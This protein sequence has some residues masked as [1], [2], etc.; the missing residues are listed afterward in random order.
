MDGVQSPLPP[1]R[2]QSAGHCRSRI[3]PGSIPL[4]AADAFFL[5]DRYGL[6][7][8]TIE[9]A[10]LFSIEGQDHL[11]GLGA[12]LVYAQLPSLIGAPYLASPDHEGAV[13]WRVWRQPGFTANLPLYIPPGNDTSPVAVLTEDEIAALG[14]AQLGLRAVGLQ[15]AASALG[16]MDEIAAQLLASGVKEV[17]ILF[18]VERV[19]ASTSV[20]AHDRV[21]LALACAFS[22]EKHG[23]PT[24]VVE[25]PEKYVTAGKDDDGQDCWRVEVAEAVGC[26]LSREEIDGAVQRG[27]SFWHHPA[28]PHAKVVAMW[29][30]EGEGVLEHIEDWKHLLARQPSGVVQDCFS[31]LAG[32]C[33]GACFDHH[34]GGYSRPL[35]DAITR[36]LHRVVKE[37]LPGARLS[38]VRHFI[39]GVQAQLDPLA[40]PGR[41]SLSDFGLEIRDGKVFRKPT[42]DGARRL[43]A[44]FVP[45]RIRAGHVQYLGCTP[46]PLHES[47]V[48]VGKMAEEITVRIHGSLYDGNAFRRASQGRLEVARPQD[49]KTLMSYLVE[50]EEIVMPDA[51][52]NQT[53]HVGIVAEQPGRFVVSDGID[54]PGG[55]EECPY[56]GVQFSSTG[57][58]AFFARAAKLSTD[59][60]VEIILVHALGAPLKA[61]TGTWP[62]NGVE[63]DTTS[64]KSTLIDRVLH[65]LE[66]VHF[67]PTHFR[68]SY[69]MKKALSNA[70]IPIALDEIGRISRDHRRVLVD[71]LN[72]S[73]GITPSTHGDGRRVYIV[74]VPAILFG[75]DLAMEDDTALATKMIKVSLDPAKKDPEALKAL[76]ESEAHFPTR[77]WLEFLADHMGRHDVHA[78]I[79]E[80][81]ESMRADVF[82]DR[83]RLPANADRFL[84]N[85]AA[86]SYAGNI[87]KAFGTPVS[88]AFRQNLLRAAKVHFDAITGEVGDGEDRTSI[89]KQIVHDL[90]A[91]AGTTK[92]KPPFPMIL[93]ARGLLFHVPTAVRYLQRSG[94]R[95]DITSPTAAT[96][97]LRELGSPGHR[98]RFCRIQM[99]LFLISADVLRELG[100]EVDGHSGDAGVDGEE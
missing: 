87:L 37:I 100:Y 40:A 78:E 49:F 88:E 29:R 35:L 92:S 98:Q 3:T 44:N 12:G 34:G 25:L 90:I 55:P 54:F 7:Q 65:P 26:G 52:L 72:E 53:L 66:I 97:L 36:K 45:R 95:Y 73:Y 2:S 75:Q 13:G 51:A 83:Q 80:R 18:G 20:E 59:G 39:D 22:L 74:S 84:W 62:H 15:G 43:V 28:P 58:T 23:V 11:D 38:S 91:L 67:G 85:W 68:T 31:E 6:T 63:G 56:S 47:D 19:K 9:A 94:C 46:E 64:G 96:R 70:N 24:T 79:L 61:T 42:N 5:H 16:R 57:D 10:R 8:Q 1:H 27:H 86:V 89:A 33:R 93:D 81:A 32:W 77:A 71:L 76:L 50:E 99:R 69:R 17:R 48:E 14:L 60:T 21:G 30:A 4:S 41:V 82:G